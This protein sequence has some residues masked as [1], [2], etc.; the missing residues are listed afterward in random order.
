MSNGIASDTSNADLTYI[1][2]CGIIKVVCQT[3]TPW[4][5]LSESAVSQATED[6]KTALV[7]W[8]HSASSGTHGDIVSQFSLLSH[9]TVLLQHCK[10]PLC[11]QLYDSLCFCSALSTLSALTVRRTFFHI[12][13]VTGEQLMAHEKCLNE[14]SPRYILESE[15]VGWG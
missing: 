9:Y 15:T 12:E 13:L 14:Y 5:H 6:L 3:E 8:N 10:A 7:S 1:G 2:K 11:T 4:R